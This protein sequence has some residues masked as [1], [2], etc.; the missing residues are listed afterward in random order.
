MAWMLAVVLYDEDTNFVTDDPVVNAIG[1]P[2]HQI[3][4]PVITHDP[5]TIRRFENA[6]DTP[7]KLLQKTDAEAADLPF[8][9]SGGRYQLGLCSSMIDQPHS[10]ALRAARI[11]CS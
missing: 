3:A 11:T 4:S 9:E 6:R 1:K 7:I 2:R 8:I 5:P 10:I